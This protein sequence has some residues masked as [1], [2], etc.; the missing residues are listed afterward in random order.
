MRPAEIDR[1]DA[2]LQC[3]RMR[4]MASALERRWEECDA[5]LPRAT[6]IGRDAQADIPLPEIVARVQIQCDALPELDM[7]MQY[8]HATEACAV[9]GLSDFVAEVAQQFARR[10]S[11]DIPQHE[12]GMLWA[13]FQKRFAHDWLAAWTS[14]VPILAT[15][16]G[17]AHDE[18]I[19]QFQRWD[20]DFV[21]TTHRYMTYSLQAQRARLSRKLEHEEPLNPLMRLAMVH[22]KPLPSED[23][24]HMLADLRTLQHQVSLKRHKP[25]RKLID[26]CGPAMQFMMPCWM[27]SPLTVSEFV[28]PTRMQFDLVIFDE[29]SQVHAQDAISSIIRGKQL[30]VVGDTRQLPP[31]NFFEKDLSPNEE[32]D[33]DDV[34]D[35]QPAESIL[36]ECEM[37]LPMYSLLFHYRSKHEA[38]IAFSNAHFYG[39]KLTTFPSAQA[40]FHEGVQFH[41]VPD[42][43][44]DRG[45]SRT[46]AREAAMVAQFVLTH[47]REHP[48]QSLGVVAFSKAQQDAIADALR[49]QR[50]AMPAWE[51]FFN[52]DAPDPFFIRNL[53]SV[54]GDERDVIILSVGY[55]KDATG[56]VYQNFGPLGKEGGERRL[57]V[58]ITRARYQVHL[59]SSMRA[60]DIAPTA[61]KGVQ[62]LR[63]YLEYAEHGPSSLPQ[64]PLEPIAGDHFDSL[65]EEQVCQMLRD[66]GMQVETQVGCSGYRID[67]AIRDPHDPTHFILGVECDGARYHSAK[68][69]R[70]RDRLRQRHLES[71][72]WRIHRI[73]SR[74]WFAD[75]NAQIL[76][77]MQRLDGL[78]GNRASR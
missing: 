31:T 11:S 52:E 43:V 54:Q 76:R 13:I 69:A 2:A 33:T 55:G 5:I 38:L 58:A 66:R 37:M 10:P 23:T 61:G 75:P 28:D 62:S 6:F 30:I 53:E 26:L 35:A 27:M 3:E 36:Q 8:R 24:E 78:M 20:A 56:R 9:A 44:Y 73:W 51:A 59:V 19:T 22:T 41:F 21:Q 57:N 47:A 67:L 40:D 49:L 17:A 60:G 25:I 4:Q 64:N 71:L 39:G 32:S 50:D 70:D 63:A 12:P 34:L 46:N 14:D 45:H 29:A 74:D 15:F 72:G 65:F 42:G 68:T 77:V 16:R 1:Q 18:Q 7:W 48:D